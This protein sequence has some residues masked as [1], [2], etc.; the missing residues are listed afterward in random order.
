MYKK[1][2]LCVLVKCSPLLVCQSRAA[3]R[4]PQTKEVGAVRSDSIVSSRVGCASYYAQKFDGRNTYYG[5][6]L[7]NEAYTCA[8]PS[9]PYGT[10]VRV[11]NLRNLASV[12]VRVTDRFR[13]KGDHLIDITRRAAKDIDL[14][15]YG[16]ARVRVEVLAPGLVRW[17][18][19]QDTVTQGLS[20]PCGLTFLPVHTPSVAAPVRLPSF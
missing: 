19:P 9:L 16:M 10:W 18:M 17:L 1:L 12:L 15:R 5:D 2:L 3:E 4:H 7:D 20:V 13:P 8:H 11:V 6:R 14:L